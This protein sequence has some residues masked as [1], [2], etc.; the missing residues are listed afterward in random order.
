MLL[1]FP[2]IQLILELH[3]VRIQRLIFLI[4]HLAQ[5]LDFIKVDL[6]GE[7]FVEMLVN[8][9]ENASELESVLLTQI[10]C[11]FELL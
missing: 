10:L 2:L 1:N 7:I 8:T 4:N 3:Q 5:L 9:I 6:I 11:L